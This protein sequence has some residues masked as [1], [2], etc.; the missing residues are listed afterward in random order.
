MVH[1]TKLGVALTLATTAAIVLLSSETKWVEYK[2]FTINTTTFLI[3]VRVEASATKV[4]SFAT[5]VVKSGA[6]QDTETVQVST[7]DDIKCEDD[8]SQL[9][10]ENEHCSDLIVAY[11]ISMVALLLACVALAATSAMNITNNKSEGFAYEVSDIVFKRTTLAATALFMLAFSSGIYMVAS[12][13]AFHEKNGNDAI[14]V[15]LSQMQDNDARSAQ[16]EALY[17][18]TYGAM[19]YIFILTN[20]IGPGLFCGAVAYHTYTTNDV[21]LFADYATQP[22][23]Y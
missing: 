21:S 12:L 23:S 9:G 18:P 8:N 5:N 19:Y 13:D 20:I 7:W 1:K 2:A 10:L 6:N 15:L 11:D 16:T 4:K 22:L 17:S 3:N 14:K